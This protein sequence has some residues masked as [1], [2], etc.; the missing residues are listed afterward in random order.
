MLCL[1][2]WALHSP[3]P[4]LC[5]SVASTSISMTTIFVQSTKGVYYRSGNMWSNWTRNHLKRGT[6]NTCTHIYP[7]RGYGKQAQLQPDNMTEMQRDIKGL[8]SCVLFYI[9]SPFI[10][11]TIWTNSKHLKS[12]ETV[13]LSHLGHILGYHSSNWH[14]NVT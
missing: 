11:M 12:Q 14:M 10:H 9:C 2:Q 7:L 3:P 8:M 13:A 5:Y 1:R 4:H 6:N